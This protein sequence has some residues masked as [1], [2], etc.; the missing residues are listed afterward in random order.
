MSLGFHPRGKCRKAGCDP[1]IGGLPKDAQIWLEGGQHRADW[2]RKKVGFPRENLSV[3]AG[4]NDFSLI[5]ASQCME[6]AKA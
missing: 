1:Q 6:G 5:L 2:P 3:K 4:L